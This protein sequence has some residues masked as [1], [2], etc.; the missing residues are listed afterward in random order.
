MPVKIN[1]GLEMRVWNRNHIDISSILIPRRSGLQRT[2]PS[3]LNLNLLV[4]FRL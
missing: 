4:I 3:Y 2:I 1:A